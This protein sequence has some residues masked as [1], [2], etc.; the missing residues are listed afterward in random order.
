MV[1][2]LS[3]NSNFKDLG[4]A[5]TG[6]SKGWVLRLT[7]TNQVATTDNYRRSFYLTITN[8]Y[9]SASIPVYCKVVTKSTWQNNYDKYYGNDLIVTYS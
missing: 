8:D 2:S 4:I 7:K 5:T 6:T 1:L 3:S 9:G